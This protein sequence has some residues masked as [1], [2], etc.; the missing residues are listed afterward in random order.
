MRFSVHTGPINGSMTS[1]TVWSHIV[2]LAHFIMDCPKIF[3]R[4]HLM[5]PT[6]ETLQLFSH[7]AMCPFLYHFVMVNIHVLIA[8]GCANVQNV[9]PLHEYILSYEDSRHNPLR[10]IR[11]NTFFFVCCFGNLIHCF[12]I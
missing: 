3:D 5:L 10:S 4:G 11:H 6:K 8:N 7:F 9:L 2:S 12:Y 1:R